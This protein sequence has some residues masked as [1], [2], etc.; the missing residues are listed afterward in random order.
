V[1]RNAIAVL[2][3]FALETL[4]VPLSALAADPVD[5][6]ANKRVVL[7]FYEKVINQKNVDAALADIGPRYIQHN[8]F[9]ADGIDGLRDAIGYMKSNFPSSH[10]EIKA[11]FA[12]G[13]F[14][15]LHVLAVRERGSRGAAIVDIFRLENGRIVEH[16]DVTQAIPEGPAN[17]NTMF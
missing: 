5:V 4:M 6:E 2:A 14:V 13:N 7:D 11:V 3:L 10:S 17:N 9:V 8:P 15:I 1:K 16:W 12:D